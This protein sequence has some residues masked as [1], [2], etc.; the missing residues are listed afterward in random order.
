MINLEISWLLVPG[1]WVSCQYSR[2]QISLCKSTN[3]RYKPSRF[4]LALGCLMSLA[5]TQLLTIRGFSCVTGHNGFSIL[6]WFF[7]RAVPAFGEHGDLVFQHLKPSR[8]HWNFAPGLPLIPLGVFTDAGSGAKTRSLSASK[9]Q[10]ESA[11]SAFDLLLCG[12]SSLLALQRCQGCSCFDWLH[13]RSLCFMRNQYECFWRWCCNFRPSRELTSAIVTVL[14][15]SQTRAG[16]RE[17]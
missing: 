5:G 16:R 14:T 3:S 12:K 8:R 10:F 2:F 13:V 15:R 7:L 4:S 9:A 6:E 11:P 1:R 17:A